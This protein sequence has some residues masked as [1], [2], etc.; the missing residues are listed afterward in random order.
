MSKMITDII[1][2]YADMYN[3]SY[4]DSWHEVSRMTNFELLQL[5]M[6]MKHG[7]SYIR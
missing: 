7:N 4:E 1:K 3:M 6:E 5:Q 2:Y